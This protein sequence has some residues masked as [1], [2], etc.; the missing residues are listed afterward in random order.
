[1]HRT[2]TFGAVPLP[3]SLPRSLYRPADDTPRHPALPGLV[4]LSGPRCDVDVP[5]AG[6][7]VPQTL[8][9]GEQ[10]ANPEFKMAAG[11]AAFVILGGTDLEAEDDE[12]LLSDRSN[13]GPSGLAGGSV[14]ATFTEEELKQIFGSRAASFMKAAQ[15][16]PSTGSTRSVLRHIR[17][18]RLRMTCLMRPCRFGWRPSCLVAPQLHQRWRGAHAHRTAAS[19]QCAHG[20]PPF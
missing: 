9:S 2:D 16:T 15:F 8:P 14:A 12:E 4:K 1:M 18:S 13:P 17:M 5:T 11:V 7:P 6:Q 3:T 19:R 10:P 20:L